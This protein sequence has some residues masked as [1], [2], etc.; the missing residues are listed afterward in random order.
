MEAVQ[1]MLCESTKIKAHARGKSKKKDS[2]T[3]L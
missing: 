1:K 2:E 3:L